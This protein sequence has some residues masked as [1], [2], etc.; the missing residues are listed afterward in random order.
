MKFATHTQV[1]EAYAAGLGEKKW[2]PIEQKLKE[3]ELLLY[4]CSTDTSPA[5]RAQEGHDWIDV[6]TAQHCITVGLGGGGGL[7]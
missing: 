1:L 7:A 6:V 5:A 2:N 4:V 3:G